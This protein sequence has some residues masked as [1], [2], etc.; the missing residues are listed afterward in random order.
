M[1]MLQKE[2]LQLVIR[3]SSDLDLKKRERSRKESSG[4]SKVVYI[5]G[6]IVGNISYLIYLCIMM[7]IQ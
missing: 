2:S 6:G 7:M 3:V 1:S 5:V 4:V